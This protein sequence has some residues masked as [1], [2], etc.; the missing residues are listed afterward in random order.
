MNKPVVKLHNWVRCGNVLWGE[1]HGHPRFPDG[2]EVCTS[3]ILGGDCV[4][5]GTVETLN[6]MYELSGRES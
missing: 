4:E 2:T 6:T 3:L 5:G 1:A